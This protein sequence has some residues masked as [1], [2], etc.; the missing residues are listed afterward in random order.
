MRLDADRFYSEG[1]D[2]RH[3][4]PLSF[5][6]EVLD[7][8]QG[9][10]FSSPNDVFP[11]DELTSFWEDLSKTRYYAAI[12]LFWG[13]FSRLKY[14]FFRVPASETTKWRHDLF[15]PYPVKAMMFFGKGVISFGKRSIDCH[16]W[17]KDLKTTFSEEDIVLGTVAS[18]CNSNPTFCY[19][20]KA[21]TD[22]YV[23]VCYMGW[24]ENQRRG[25]II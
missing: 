6:Q 2:I 13:D 24:M 1:F 17:A 14:K 9:S 23:S 15:E 12:T 19:S 3:D 10:S 5:Y 22:L 25:N 20:I 8:S 21:E 4:A 11:S 7:K 18:V 16:G